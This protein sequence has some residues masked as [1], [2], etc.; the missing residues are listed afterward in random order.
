MAIQVIN[1]IIHG[2]DKDQH[3]TN[4]P[5]KSI[6]IKNKVLNVDLPAV[7]TLVEGVSKLLGNKINAQSWG[8]F[9]VDRGGKFYKE[10]DAGLHLLTD[11]KYFISLTKKAMIEII[12]FSEKVA[13]STGSK[14]LFSCYRDD[15][16][17]LRLLVAM[18]KQKGGITLDDDYI[19]VDVVEIDMSKLS[20]AADIRC[21]D[22]FAIKQ[23]EDLFVAGSEGVNSQKN[24]SEDGDLKNYLSFLS[25]RDAGEA[26][27][28]FIKALGCTLNISPRKSTA[29]VITATLDF[30]ERNEALKPYAKSAREAVC[31][32]L[33]NQLEKKL[34]AKLEEIVHAASSVVPPDL[35]AN[36]EGFEVYF[37]SEDNKISSEFY[38][39]NSELSKHIKVFVDADDMQLKFNKSAVG[40]DNNSR[41]FYNRAAKMLTIKN[42]TVKQM[43]QLDK[44]VA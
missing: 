29:V 15:L 26:S 3:T 41:V 2:F 35:S 28:Y 27:E 7:K 44:Q 42:L 18:I 25:S 1:A 19:P 31:K 24:A 38:V 10:F 36:L 11:E 20:Q 17:R 14:I 43:E 4:V 34:P 33:Q 23:Y 5:Q 12:E 40:M 30:F 13:A 8:R 32:Y 21:D 9:D 6:V 22:Y 39:H 16:G 37:N